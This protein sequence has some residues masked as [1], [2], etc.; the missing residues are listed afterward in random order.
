MNMRESCNTTQ[1]EKKFYHE[2]VND[3]ASG[4]IENKPYEKVAATLTKFWRTTSVAALWKAVYRKMKSI[5]GQTG[6]VENIIISNKGPNLFSFSFLSS[7]NVSSISSDGDNYGDNWHKTAAEEGIWPMG[8]TKENIMDT[9]KHSHDCVSA[10]TIEDASLH[11]VFDK[12]T[13]ERKREFN[14]DADIPNKTVITGAFSHI[15][16]YKSPLAAAM[17]SLVELCIKRGKICQPLSSGDFSSDVFL[18]WWNWSPISLMTPFLHWLLMD[19]KAGSTPTSSHTSTIRN[20]C[21][22]CVLL[23]PMLLYYGSWGCIWTKEKFKTRKRE[24]HHS[25]NTTITYQHPS[26]PLMSSQSWI[27]YSTNYLLMIEEMNRLL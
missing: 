13:K 17:K 2:A 7:S 1:L 21:G 18:I 27:N 3:L 6:P 23:S 16:R 8:S 24:A 20:T 19:T 22:K 14:V 15:L 25:G 4:Q 11:G 5:N 10:I 12:L 26:S 9:K